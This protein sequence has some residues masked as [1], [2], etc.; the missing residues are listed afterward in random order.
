MKKVYQHYPYTQSEE[1]RQGKTR[2][3]EVIV[4]GG[5]MVGLTVALELARRNVSVVLL[6]D[7]DTVSIGSRGICHAKRSLEIWDRIGCAESLLEKGASWSVGK[8][9]HRDKLAYRFNLLPED[10]H[11]MPAMIN[12]QQYYVEETL[13]DM[14]GQ[15][16]RIDLRWKHKVTQVEPHQDHVKVTVQTP[17]G[18]FDME[19][20]WLLACDGAGSQ[21][22]NQLGV[23]LTGRAFEDHFLIA[24]VCMKAD[25]PTERW[26]WFDPPFHSGE[27]SLLHKQADNIWRIDFQLGRD[28]DSVEEQKPENVIP[29]IKAMLGDNHEFELEWVSIYRFACRRAERFRHGRII[30]VGDAA[31]QVSPFGARGGNSGIQDADNLCWKLPLV[32]NGEAPPGLIDSYDEERGL[33]ADDNLLK[34]ARATDFMSPKSRSN[35]HFRDSILELAEDYAF[36]RPLVNS[37][38]LSTPSAYPDSSLNTL[39]PKANALVA[40]GTHCPDAAIEIDGRQGWLL[41]QLSDGFTLLLTADDPAARALPQALGL[42]TLVC[43]KSFQDNAGFVRARYGGHSAEQATVYLIR[44]DQYVAACW[45]NFDYNAVSSALAKAQGRAAG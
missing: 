17:D 14:I 40:P 45:D 22:R 34:S 25:F 42:R 28:A 11:K 2:Y 8:V 12:L 19:A 1:Q 4:V 10:G 36:A 31:H 15:K 23:Q 37:G 24:D 39:T 44:P 35:R 43:G 16:D 5:G 27:S 41:N 32:I 7:N 29:R 38:R 33:A 20:G 18:V 21:I 30:L 6:D 13:V 26:F 9:F 3:H